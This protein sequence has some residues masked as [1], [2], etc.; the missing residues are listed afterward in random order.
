MK[1]L[2][3]R[4]QGRLLAGMTLGLWIWLASPGAQA[5]LAITE[6]MTSAAT[7]Y[8]G[9][10]VDAGPDFFEL[11]NFGTNTLDLTGYSWSD[12]G[13]SPMG[14]PFLGVSIGSNESIIFFRKKDVETP[15]G[16]RQWWGLGDQVQVIPWL[17]SVGLSAVWERVRI[18]DAESNL[19]DS[20]DMG[21]AQRGVTFTYDTNCGFF[22]VFSLP[23][24]GCA[25]PAV[26]ADDVGS[27]GCTAG[28]VQPCVRQQ[29]TSLE[30]DADQDATFSIRAGAVP[31][32]C[33]QWWFS[34]TPISG[35]T[36]AA[37]TITNAQ[38]GNA[39]PYWVQVENVVGTLTSQVAQL[40]VSTNPHAP[41]ILQPPQDMLIYTGQCASFTVQAHGYPGLSYQ[42][43]SNGLSMPGATSKTL[44]VCDAALTQTD[45]VYRVEVRNVLGVTNASARLRVTP[46]PRLVITE[47][48]AWPATNSPID[49][50]DWF[51]LTNFD[52]NAVSLQN[53]RFFDQPSLDMPC[54]IT[55]AITIQ[56]AQSIIF[57]ERMTP[58]AFIAWWGASNLPPGVTIIPWAGFGISEWGGTLNV[59]NPS[60]AGPEDFV[61][62]VLL[63]R[64]L[65][66]ISY[67]F[68]PNDPWREPRPSVLGTG[69]AFRAVE[70]NDIGSP[71]Y[72][73]HARP[74]FLGIGV[75]GEMVTI[76]WQAVEGTNYVLWYK[77]TL[78]GSEAWTPVGTYHSTGRSVTAQDQN[79]GGASQRFYRVEE[80]P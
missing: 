36:S 7:N 38:P 76:T 26:T 80:V 56:P 71:G 70:D 62:R 4:K 40:T 51:E 43:S 21:E 12:K 35:A 18:W 42:W 78:G 49:H 23:G 77:P 13:N 6:V 59:W 3:A 74:R 17:E 15:E 47:V 54:V 66:G 75:E 52:T 9:S 22:G 24:V 63:A 69:G 73:P 45:I 32:P 64:S 48:M 67:W 39:G 55:Q 44:T 50:R 72:C 34:N 16:F 30:V 79:P 60:A 11:T 58:E 46:K 41:A 27:P 5:Q 14:A 29:P 61:A 53:W 28:P 68:D 10:R 37:L 2:L 33:Y 65:M 19:V 1:N 57:V 20:V 8:G 25:F 31:P